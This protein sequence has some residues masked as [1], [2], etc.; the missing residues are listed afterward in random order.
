MD[1][2]GKPALLEGTLPQPPTSVTLS[3]EAP[4][5]TET[6]LESQL[7]QL[8]RTTSCMQSQRSVPGEDSSLQRTLLAAVYP[9]LPK[10]GKLTARLKGNSSQSQKA[11]DWEGTAHHTYTCT[12]GALMGLWGTMKEGQEGSCFY[13]R[14]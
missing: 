8:H 1:L 4:L 13:I 3:E 10:S 9:A 6:W 2:S 7:L 5:S 11:V 14:G 12:S